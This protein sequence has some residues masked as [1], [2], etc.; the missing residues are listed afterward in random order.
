[1]GLDQMGNM[2][3]RREGTDPDALPVYVGSH[4]D[5]QPTGGKYDGILG[6]LGGLEILRTL[7]N[8]SIKTKNT[9]N[10]VVYGIGIR[11]FF[12]A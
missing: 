3:A 5:T 12:R 8:L 10:T 4:L 6:V 2:F 1:M 9:V 11:C 7:N